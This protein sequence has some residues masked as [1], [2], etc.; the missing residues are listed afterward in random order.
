MQ[1]LKRIVQYLAGTVDL[2]IRY[3]PS[4]ENDRGL[5]GYTDS[6][7]GDDYATRSHSGYV[8]KLW[9]GPISHSSRGQHTVATSSTEAK[10]VAECNAAKEV[11]FLA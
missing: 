6:A 11:F 2:G 8:F 1:A 10:Y 3:G 9:N 7:Y 5:I 4:D